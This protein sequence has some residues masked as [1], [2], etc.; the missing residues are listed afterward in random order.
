MTSI[1]DLDKRY[2][3]CNIIFSFTL[4]YQ[5]QVLYLAYCDCHNYSLKVNSSS[6]DGTNRQT[7]LHYP[8]TACSSYNLVMFSLTKFED[9]LYLSSSE[10]D[11]IYSFKVND[12][13]ITT[14]IN[15]STFCDIN[16]RNSLIIVNEY[17][18]QGHVW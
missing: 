11:K 2:Y 9:T 18:P 13:N 4:D 8:N 7:V 1:I 14:I 5:T 15:T 16:L 12:E 17:K 10:S 6:T 3:D